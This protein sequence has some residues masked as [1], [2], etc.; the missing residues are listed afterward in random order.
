MRRRDFIKA[1]AGSAIAWPLTTHAQQARI[2]QIGF[3]SSATATG[4]AKKFEALQAGLRDFG[5]LEGKNIVI[6]SRWAEG[7]YNQL[8]ALASE[9]VA[10]KVDVL[11]TH[12]TPATSALKKATA[13]IPIV[14]AVSG[15][16]EK[17]G[18]IQTLARPGGNVTGLT[19]F[20][21]EQASK[22]LEV[23]KEVIPSIHRVAWLTNPENPAMRR[24]ELPA[25]EDAVRSLKITYETFEV[26]DPAELA[27]VFSTIAKGNFDMVEIA[28]DGMLVG[29][30]ARI[31]TL[32]LKEHLP[33]I[34]EVSFDAEGGLVGLGP[35]TTEMF[36]RAAYYVDRLLKGEKAADLPVERPTKYE[37]NINLKTAK[38]LGISVPE[39]VLVR[40]DNVI[41]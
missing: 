35:D 17:T 16:A 1:V 8:A 27:N 12:G 2:A 6:H 33:A 29:N 28:Q 34:G 11:V 22:R 10:L 19:Y 36:R 38:A 13:T 39:A 32:A 31:A 14:M 21:G 3:L 7:N 4:Y 18:L 20:A 5:Y 37:L 9:L 23:M 15:D 26:R 25:V 24:L 41:E 40:A 30:F